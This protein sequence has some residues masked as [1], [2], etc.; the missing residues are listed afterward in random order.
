MRALAARVLRSHGY[1]VYDAPHG[2]AALEVASTTPALAL[3]LVITDV[4]MPQ[5]SGRDVAEQLELRFPGVKVLY[6]SGYT[7]HAI[8]HEGQLNPGI[9]FLHKPFTPGALLRKVRSVID[10]PAAAAV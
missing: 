8:V 4:V 6:I 3:D 9:A 1:Q 2:R 10:G 7:D 5:M